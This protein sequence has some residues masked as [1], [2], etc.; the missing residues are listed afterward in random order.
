MQAVITEPSRAAPRYLSDLFRN[1]TPGGLSD[2]EL[3]ERFAARV[4]EH[5]EA[6]DLA[7]AALLARHGPMVLRVCRAVLGDRH[8][9]EEAF[10]ATFLVL[11]VR[12]RSIR[13]R[14][15]VGSWLHG[16]ALRVAASE[17]SRAARRRRHE[18]VRA[19]M[20]PSTTQGTESDPVCD[21]ERTLVLQEEIGGLPEKDRAAVVLCYLEGLTHEMAA[22]RLGWPL[23][24]VKSCLARAR[25]RL[26][27]RLTRRGV[28]PSTLPFDRCASE[29][30]RT[31]ALIGTSLAD[32]TLRGALKAGMGQG[33]LAGIVSAEAVVLMEGIIRSMTNARLM[34]MATAALI[35]GL[36]TA[37]A[38]VMG[39]SAMRQENP[40]RASNP[41]QDARQPVAA[42]Q[43]VKDSPR[44]AATDQ[45]PLIIHVEVVDPEGRRLS[46]AVVAVDV[47]YARNSESI[48]SVF[49]RV[50]TDG[51]GQAQVAVAR[52][53][54]GA[55]WAR[56]A[57]FWAY[58]PGRAI[59]LASFGSGASGT[60]GRQASPLLVPLTL[61]QPSKCTITVVGPDDRPIAGLRLTPHMLRR[62]DGRYVPTV[63]DALREP[64]TATTDTR[65]VATLTY[66]PKIMMPMAIRVAGPEVAPH[67]LALDVPQGRDAVLK[68]G[69]A[70][71]LVGIVR[72]ASGMPLA[73]VPVELWVQGADIRRNDFSPS[74]GS[75]RITTDEILQLDPRPLKTGSQGEFQT[76]ATLLSGS[77]YRV[78]I[79]HEGFV[80]F[81][82]NWVTLNGE[83]AT[84]PPIRLQ[85]LQTVT[86]QIQD[87]QGRAIA[88]ARVFVPAG[89]PAT[90]TDAGGRFTLAGMNPG[91]AV[92]LVEQAGFRLQGRLVDPSTQADA[93]SLTL[94]RASEPPGPVMK[95]IADPIPP[96][97]S[98]ALAYRLL[99]PY[100]RD[101]M[102]K[103]DDELKLTAISALSEFDP[104]RALELLQN[105]QFRNEDPLY[106][107]IRESM[108]ARLA[109]TD[110][111]RA[112]AMLEPILDPVTKIRALTGVAKALPASERGRRQAL[113]ERAA[114]L[115][116]DRLKQAN[117]LYCVQLVT[118][119][120]EQWLD[121]GERDRA[122]LMLEEVKLSRTV[123]QTGFLGQLARLEP[124]R[125]QARLRE[126]ST[127]RVDPSLR[128]LALTEIAFQLAIDRA[129]EAEQLF[130]LREGGHNELNSMTHIPRFCRRLARIDPTR[131][132]RVAASLADPGPRAYAWAFV[133]LGL[134]EK[135]QAGA[136]EAMDRAIQELDRLRESGPGSEEGGRGFVYLYRTNPAAL[137]LPIV[138][139]VAP[140]RLAEVFW[141][142]V[143]LQTRIETDR[144]YQL[145]R[146][147][148]GFECEL[149]ARYDRPVAAAL[150]EPINSSLRSLAARSAPP[151]E[152]DP[153]IIRAQGYIDPRAAV[154]LLESLTSPRESRGLDPARRA[155]IRLAEAL[156]SPRED[157]WMRRWG[158]ML[159]R[160]D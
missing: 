135:D 18:R 137:I 49:E 65:G 128:D 158:A 6:A 23:G 27:V 80:P 53:R 11:A 78:S 100:L 60:F 111:A 130:Y 40:R 90:T 82:S 85:P 123:F 16:V 47:S 91:K 50:H 105:G 31:P 35:A 67:T 4:G 83:R 20:T 104:D 151:D 54:L 8:E 109:V 89:G 2:G 153:G 10:Q 159:Q 146:S 108:A 56:S 63:P 52:E 22:E 25:E 133:A 15:S 57:N 114:T 98:R 19:A 139:R 99:E 101:P 129:A 126:L 13:R 17:H 148:A 87:R 113:L 64:M 41:G 5:D 92:I 28:A 95:P 66:L 38:G 51:A 138:E 33:S 119:L 120:A 61:E 134:A 62:T 3:L 75:R 12:A 103:D 21:Y 32:A 44:P 24:S 1:G 81:D 122:R 97:E 147:N 43:V 74:F 110:P 79:R 115:L 48:E 121:M 118:A 145:L 37:G 125:I 154:A 39:N 107:R 140:D 156:G 72:T 94:V 117:D 26:R 69:R 59:A 76:P 29:P 7:F 34:L 14:G 131:A 102:E 70:G 84:I 93:G 157:R 112:E 68:L 73:G 136:S 88:V 77:T 58:Q 36:A 45:G 86:G 132:R 30:A 106:Q 71:R 124:D 152:I 55:S 144:D 116:R 46:G 149:L 96:E 141:R 155:R 127:L 42:G 9:V 143:A 142:A 150:L 160:D